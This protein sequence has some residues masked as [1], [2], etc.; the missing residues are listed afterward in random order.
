M[1][2]RN[3]LVYSVLGF[4]LWLAFL[5]S[6]IHATVAGVILA[7]TIPASA[8]INTK[9]FLSGGRQLLEK[10]DKA[11]EEGPDV[12]T[13]EERQ[14][15]VQSLDENC[16]QIMTPLQR[17]EHTLHPWVSFIIMPLF[18]FANAGVAISNNF[19]TE[20][21]NPISVGIIIGLFFGKQLGIFI[22]TWLSVKFNIASVPFGVSWKQIYAA[23]IL[24]GIGF[25]MSLFIAN[26]AFVYEDLLNISKVGIL[27]ASLLSGLLGFIILRG[28]LKPKIISDNLQHR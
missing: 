3:L 25:T 12:L 1:G 24:A 16:E 4:F 5:G 20:L 28:T 27:S 15:Y 13:N 22:F 21:T 9:Q 6:G 10:F 26:L 17:F 8:K 11:G 14:S 2:L 18:A 19:L 23:G 7:F